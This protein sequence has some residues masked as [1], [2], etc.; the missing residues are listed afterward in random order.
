MA[1]KKKEAQTSPKEV[2]KND[3]SPDNDPRDKTEADY[4]ASGEDKEVAGKTGVK[5]KADNI[6]LR[7]YG[8]YQD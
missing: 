4:M 3:G 2:K 1:Q 6:G 5:D 7:F 8:P